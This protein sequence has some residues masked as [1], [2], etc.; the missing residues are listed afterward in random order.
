M[1][2]TPTPNAFSETDADASIVNENGSKRNSASKPMW[3]LT[4]KSLKPKNSS[5]CAPNCAVLGVTAK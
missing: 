5:A 4:L 1:L 2:K 3:P